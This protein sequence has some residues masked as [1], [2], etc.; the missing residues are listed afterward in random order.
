MVERSIQSSAMTGEEVAIAIIEPTTRASENPRRE[1]ESA[2]YCKEMLID[3]P[4]IHRVVAGDEGRE[5]GRHAGAL[6][7]GRNENT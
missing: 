2:G 3:Q 4:E 5:R 7:S 6:T 1:P